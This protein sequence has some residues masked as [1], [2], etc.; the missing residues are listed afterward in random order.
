M[1]LLGLDI[2]LDMLDVINKRPNGSI[3]FELFCHNLNL[4]TYRGHAENDYSKCEYKTLVLG[5]FVNAIKIL[6]L[7][8]QLCQSIVCN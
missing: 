5:G 3:S 7:S 4:L 6:V 1:T 8:K 2:G